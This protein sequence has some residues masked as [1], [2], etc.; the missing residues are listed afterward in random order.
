M[1]PNR[2]M[3]RHAKA[4]ARRRGDWAWK[5]L[6]IDPELLKKFPAV[7]NIAQAW[8]N[9]FYVVQVYRVATELGEVLHLC[10]TGI[11]GGE[12]P[13]RDMQ[14]IKD[15]IIGTDAEAVQV[16]PKKRDIMDQADIYHLFILPSEWPIPFGL[17]RENGLRGRPT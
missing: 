11:D 3:R 12:P 2:A 16:Y 7:G 9:D 6:P 8:R 13:W 5:R 4:E 17:H 14:R 1:I 15:E 10:I